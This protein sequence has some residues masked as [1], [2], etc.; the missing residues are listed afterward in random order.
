MPHHFFFFVCVEKIIW[1]KKVEQ[2]MISFLPVNRE[3]T[4][5]E[6]VEP[7]NFVITS[8]SLTLL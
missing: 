8:E 6:S 2:K 4:L 5:V 3:D 1:E 7:V